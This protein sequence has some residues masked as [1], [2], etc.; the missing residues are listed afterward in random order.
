LQKQQYS[1]ISA[2]IDGSAAFPLLQIAIALRWCGE[3]VES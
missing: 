3:A 1:V 2:A